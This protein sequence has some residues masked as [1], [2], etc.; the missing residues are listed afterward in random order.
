MNP[1]SSRSDK[2]LVV[3][4]SPDNIFLVKTILEAEGYTISSAE[5]GAEALIALQ[6][7]SCDLVLLDLMMPGMDGYEVTRRIRREINLQQYIPILLITAHDTAD[8]AQGLDLGADDFIRKPV[9]VEELLA[10]VR[11]LLRLKHSID[12][13]DQIARQREDFVSRLTHDLRTPLIAAE[14]M[15]MLLQNGALGQLS[16]EIYEVM[17]IMSRSNTNLLSM[18]N[19]LLEVYRFEAGRKSLVFQPVQL[20]QL[21]TEVAGELKPLALAKALAINLDFAGDLA[22]QAIICDRLEIHRL[23]TNLIGNAIKFTDSG[24]VTIS[25]KDPEQLNHLNSQFFIN[26]VPNNYIAIEIRDTGVGIPLAQQANIFERFRPGNHQ[27]SGSGLG[28]YLCHRIVTAHQGQIIVDSEVGKGSIFT[29]YL[30]KKQSI[31]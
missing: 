8:V 28:L 7:Y 22:A 11:S 2:I 1:Q 12:E 21:I 5:N 19:T 24:S 6:T 27:S 15:L 20:S 16:P 23:L 25:L 17:T 13:R 14:R 30:P 26:S 3:D 29:I 9:A 18:V 4:D 10:R 31:N